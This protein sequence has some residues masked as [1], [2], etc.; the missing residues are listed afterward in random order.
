MFNIRLLCATSALFLALAPV[1]AGEITDAGAAAEQ[2][3]T[4]GD[5]QAAFESIEAAK[6]SIWEQSPLALHNVNFTVGEPAGFGIY[7]VRPNNEF[8]S[9]E[10]LV[11]YTEPQGYGFGQEGDFYIMDMALDFEVKDASGASLAKQDNFASW[12]LRSR[13]PNKEFM[14][15]LTYD[16]KGITPGDY[17]LSTTVHD[18][19]SE[20]TASFSLKFKIIP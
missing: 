12:T 15:K 8:K 10:T 13:Y 14:G 5:Y 20:K 3:V 1:F 16:F 6:G 7:D 2:A 4:D 19:N 17:V 18:R 9:G 11:V